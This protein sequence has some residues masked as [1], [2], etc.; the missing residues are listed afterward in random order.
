MSTPRRP[1]PSTITR[2]IECTET[3]LTVHI[4]LPDLSRHHRVRLS[5]VHRIEEWLH[6]HG[7]SADEVVL[8]TPIRRDP[9]TRTLRWT[10]TIEASAMCDPPGTR[11]QVEQRRQEPAPMT[12]G[13]PTV[14]PAPFPSAVL[15]DVREAVTR[16]QA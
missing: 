15:E 3:E 14:W 10:G 13:D 1:D 4:S 6:A 8:G 9:E 7:L 12:L 11:I 2:P 16:D 5:T